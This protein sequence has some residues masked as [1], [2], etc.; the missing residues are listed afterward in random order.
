MVLQTIKV[1]AANRDNTRKVIFSYAGYDIEAWKKIDKD[2]FHYVVLR[3]IKNG[4]YGK[5]VSARFSQIR[6]GERD[7][8]DTGICLDVITL[9]QLHKELKSNLEML[10]IRE[11]NETLGFRPDGVFC[12]AF[13]IEKDGKIYKPEVFRGRQEVDLEVLK[14]FTKN[15]KRALLLLHTLVSPLI[16]CDDDLHDLPILFLYG[17]SSTG[18]S[19]VARYLNSLAVPP[20]DKTLL[21]FDA[22][23][24]GLTKCIVN[25]FGIPVCVD[26][27]SLVDMDSS[28]EIKALRTLIFGLSNGKERT[29]K[30][31]VGEH[32][33]TTILMTAE[34]NNLLDISSDIKGIYGRAFPMYVEGADLFDDAQEIEQ[35]RIS[36]KETAGTTFAILVSEIR[37]YGVEELLSKAHEIRKQLESECGAEI[38]KIVSRWCEY[39]SLLSVTADLVKKRF[40]LDI[41]VDEVISYMKKEIEANLCIQ[42]EDSL[43]ERVASELMPKVIKASF[44][45]PN[46]D[47]YIR[48]RDFN[49]LVKELNLPKKKSKDILFHA[50]CIVNQATPNIGKEHGRCLQLATS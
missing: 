23:K 32:F 29:T 25:N 37:K 27:T 4:T 21:D 16:A 42:Q 44:V 36:A 43:K 39:W 48:V 38:H 33:R 22:T 35:C 19:T 49:Q 41:N 7:L 20:N 11:E 28:K 26:D 30:K 3:W 14:S 24:G 45:K 1:N 5:E 10:P 6:K 12:G 40:E 18:K 17:E 9:N 8:I 46:G 2:G 47:R 31:G 13:D 50:G 34:E 15:P